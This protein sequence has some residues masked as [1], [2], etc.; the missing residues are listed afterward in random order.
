V[1]RGGH[2]DASPSAPNPPLTTATPVPPPPPQCL[3]LLEND[4]VAPDEV[5][6]ALRDG[7]DYYLASSTEPGGWRWGWGG[8]GT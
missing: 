3:R 6:G 8:G 7:L 1:P 2:A 4:Q 5:E